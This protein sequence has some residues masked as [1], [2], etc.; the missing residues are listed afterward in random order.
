MGMTHGI[1]AGWFFS[2]DYTFIH[3]FSPEQDC[4]CEQ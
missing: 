3:Y 4:H 1:A 2:A